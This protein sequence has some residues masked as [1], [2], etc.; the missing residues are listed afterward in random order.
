MDDA[1]RI[2]VCLFDLDDVQRRT[3]YV[4]RVALDRLWKW[5]PPD[6][7][8]AEQHLPPEVLLLHR[9]PHRFNHTGQRHASRFGES[10]EQRS[11]AQVVIG[12]RMGDVDRRQLFADAFDQIAEITNVGLEVLRIDQDRLGRATD[13]G[14][15][16]RRELPPGTGSCDGRNVGPAARINRRTDRRRRRR[17]G[18][19]GCGRAGFGS[20]GQTPWYG[21]GRFSRTHSF[22]SSDS[23]CGGTKPCTCQKSNGV[24][25][26]CTSQSYPRSFTNGAIDASKGAIARRRIS[27]VGSCRAMCSPMRRT[28]LFRGSAPMKKFPSATSWNSTLT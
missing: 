9:L 24:S 4:K 28:K 8:V 5:S 20:H 22:S 10:L 18:M 21:T 7:G 1:G 3:V 27:V 16:R 23:G 19:F 11:Q 13:D 6:G 2:D 14:G 26:M 25:S 15:G 12:V 17:V